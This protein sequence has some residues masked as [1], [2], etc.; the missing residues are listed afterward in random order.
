MAY[1]LLGDASTAVK[2]SWGRYNASNTTS[3]S[4][5]FNAVTHVGENRNWFDCA[6]SPTNDTQCASRQELM[7]MGFDP[8][9]AFGSNMA[10]THAV[11]AAGTVHGGGTNGDDYVQ[12]WEI[13]FP[14]SSAFG[15]L[16]A[17]PTEDPDGVKRPWVSLMNLG[18]EREL[19]TGLSVN[20]NWYRRETF[21]PIIQ[22]GRGVTHRGLDAA[23]DREP[24]R[25]LRVGAERAPLLVARHLGA[26][27]ADHLQPERRCAR[28]HRHRPVHDELGSQHRHLQRIR[29]RVQR[30]AAERDNHVRRLVDGAQ[31][32]DPFATSRRTRTGCS[33]VTRGTTTSPGCTT[34]RSQASCRCPAAG[35]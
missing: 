1:D 4:R 35:R 14:V 27:D 2:F 26:V 18:L 12:D 16:G 25:R 23:D 17:I 7:A 31:H 22:Y 30:A 29:D 24:V 5:Q 34:S 10:D 8:G 32:H 6:L 15:Q 19:V 13:G 28:P 20:F 9:V 33:S 21:D 11:G 3:Y